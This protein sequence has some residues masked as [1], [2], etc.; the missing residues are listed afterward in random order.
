MKR[1]LERIFL[2]VPRVAD[3]PPAADLSP[4]TRQRL[5]IYR[6]LLL[7]WT[8]RI[9]LVAERQPEAVDARHIADCLQLLPL[10]SAEGTVADLGSGGGLP[11]LV[12]AIALPNRRVHLIE[13]DRRKAA[14]L[15]DAAARLDLANV[16]VHAVRIEDFEPPNDLSTVTARAL[17][18]LTT[19]LTHAHRLLPPGGIA[20]FPKGR[21]AE[22]E[23]TQALPHWHMIVERFRSRTDPISTIFRISEITRAAE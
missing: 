17:A 2:S 21:N 13:A 6:D 8:S 1:P 15:I 20:L 3:L 19:L 10:V 14:F 16:T 11:G 5:V 23:L 4:I 18:P 22:Q 12:L 9:N 7:R